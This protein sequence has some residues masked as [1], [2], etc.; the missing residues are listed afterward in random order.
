MITCSV[1][2]KV[3]RALVFMLSLIVL[4]KNKTKLEYLPIE[5]GSKKH[6]GPLNS[7]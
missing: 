1:E 6:F 2:K 5:I 4:V 7:S 3:R